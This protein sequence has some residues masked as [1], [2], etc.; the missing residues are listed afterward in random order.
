M[1]YS[2][3]IGEWVPVRTALPWR[4]MRRVVVSNSAVHPVLQSCLI[5]SR[6]LTRKYGKIC[7]CHAAFGRDGK[8]ISHV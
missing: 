2:L 7:A 8:L 6:V 4:W 5:E 1:H 3:M